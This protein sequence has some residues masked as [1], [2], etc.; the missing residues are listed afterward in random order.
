MDHRK[1]GL[2]PFR[3]ST[4]SFQPG[5][6]LQMGRATLCYSS[7]KRPLLYKED[8][9]FYCPL[10]PSMILS[11]DNY[12]EIEDLVQTILPIQDEEETCINLWPIFKGIAKKKAESGKGRELGNLSQKVKNRLEE[13]VLNLD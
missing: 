8:S 5:C 9:G 13:I 11:E 7:D 12:K 6:V 1:R 4:D 10:I 3:V 2:C